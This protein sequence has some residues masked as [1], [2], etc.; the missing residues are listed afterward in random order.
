MEFDDNFFRKKIIK[1]NYNY[2]RW[3]GK[4]IFRIEKTFLKK[5]IKNKLN[6]LNK[7]RF[8]FV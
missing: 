8:K 4:N 7:F 1:I 3:L 6:T 2:D 5:I